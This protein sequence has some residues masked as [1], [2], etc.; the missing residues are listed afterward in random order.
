MELGFGGQ[1]ADE[2]GSSSSSSSSIASSAAP[3]VPAMASQA[4]PA[5][6]PT[7][8]EAQAMLAALEGPLYKTAKGRS[9]ICLLVRLNEFVL[10][11]TQTYLAPYDATAK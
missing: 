8:E 6:K 10:R 4:S 2:G 3:L 1:T 11:P 7:V 9:L 5:L